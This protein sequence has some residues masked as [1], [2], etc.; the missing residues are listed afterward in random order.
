MHGSSC[1]HGLSGQASGQ[2][3]PFSKVLYPAVAGVL[4]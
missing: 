1:A 2:F 3:S 4:L